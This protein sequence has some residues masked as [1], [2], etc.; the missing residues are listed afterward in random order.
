MTQLL[1]TCLGDFQVTLDGAPLSAFQ[2]DKV[3][4]LLVYLVVEGQVQQRAELAQF[5][6]RGYSAESAR[7]SLRQSLHYLRQLL[8]EA[9]G[10]SPL[11]APWLLLTRQTVQL[12]P[13]AAVSADVA[14]FRA[15][16]AQVAA[17]THPTLAHCQP[18]LLRLRQA[19]DLY[20]GDFL[21][22][23]TVADSEPF[24][25]WRRVL[26]E[27]LHL[28]ALE[29]LTQLANGAEAV[30]DD[31]QAIQAARRQLALE[32]WLEAAHRRVMR[33]LAR[34][35]QRAAAIAQYNRCC[36]V[37]AEELQATPDQETTAL[38]EQ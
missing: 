21:A 19:I 4:A 37:L 6:W 3:R 26:Q 18:C 14:T 25:E 35:G 8:P 22:G 16:L 20:R 33:L 27:L 7:H 24:E 13:A 31:E 28:Q 15:L 1:L 12:N 38:Y 34:R 2:T 29:A 10:G 5:L 36:Q 17:H 9:E 32:P 23:F 11:G 30:G